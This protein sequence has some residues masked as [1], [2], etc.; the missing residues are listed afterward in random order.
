MPE[1]HDTTVPDSGA[2][3]N[4][5]P[6]KR[7]K[8]NSC[9]ITLAVLLFVA[10][11]ILLLVLNGPGFRTLGKAIALNAASKQGL[12]GDFTINGSI[13]SGFSVEGLKLEG[14]KETD[15]FV[16]VE[17][18][19]VDY[20]ALDAIRDA[21]SFRWL[22]LVEI[23]NANLVIPIPGP[24]DSARTE[25]E[26][27]KPV[28]EATDFSPLW[29][30][31]ETE[32]QI[33][34]LDV[35]LLQEG[36]RTTISKLSLV[37]EPG[38]D[39]QLIVDGLEIPDQ[40]PIEGLEVNL[41]KGRQ[42]LTIGPLEATDYL[43]L[44]SLTVAEPEPG[45]FTAAT[46]L[47]AAGGILTAEVSN[48]GTFTLSQ[49]EDTR[50]DLSKI[51]LSGEEPIELAGEIA[52]LR[53][54]FDGDFESPAT[55]NVSGQIEGKGLGTSEIAIDDLT[56][57]IAD[58][59]A[60]L[61]A[62][63]AD[64][65]LALTATIPFRQAGSA[66]Q[67]ATIPIST[68]GTLQVPSLPNLLE[69][70]VDNL[71]VTGGLSL[72]LKEIQFRDGKTLQSG[73]LRLLSKDL[74]WDG[75]YLSGCELAANVE[76][77]N[78]LTFAADLGLG[79]ANRV[80]ALGNFDLDSLSYRAEAKANL[81]T[82]G[83]LGKVLASLDKEIFAGTISA[84][85][86]GT[87]ELKPQTHEGKAEVELGNFALQDGLPI[88]G[89]L[90][91]D[92][93]GTEVSL[94]RISLKT[95]QAILEGNA[96]WDGKTISLPAM[97]LVAGDRKPLRLSAEIPF[98]PEVKGSLLEQPGDVAMQLVSDDLRVDDITHFF[99]KKPPTEGSLNGMLEAE[100][101]FSELLASGDFT[102]VPTG[103]FAK[104]DAEV[105]LNFDANGDTSVPETWNLN[106]ETLLSGFRYGEIDLETIS[107]KAKTEGE[108]P[109]KLLLADVAF[110]QSTA[111]LN[112]KA[113]LGLSDA[114]KFAD[115]AKRPLLLNG[116]IVFEK[117]EQVL[118]DFAPDKAASLPL[119]GSLNVTVSGLELLEK[120][121][122][123]G[124][125]AID[126]DS[127]ALNGQVF[128]ELEI[129]AAIPEP[130]L[131]DAD[132]ALV[133]DG[134]TALRGNGTY[135]IANQE[136]AGS[137]G[138]TADMSEGKLDEILAGS[139]A[140][141]LIPKLTTLNWSGKGAIEAK[142][143]EGELKLDATRIALATG[144]EPLNLAL[145]GTYSEVS[146]DFPNFSI[147]SKPLD[148]TGSLSWKDKILRLID[149][150]GNSNGREVLSLAA[151]IPLDPEKLTA[152]TWFT[153]ETPLSLTL[154]T[155][156]LSLSNIATLAVPEIPVYGDLTIG[157]E[158]SGTPANPVMD[159]DL[160]FDKISVVQQ[161]KDLPV[162][163]LQLGLDAAGTKASV[164]GMFQHPDINPL[165]VEAQLPFHPGEWA[166][167]SR[168][169]LDESIFAA[170][171]IEP[172]PLGFLISQ[173]PGIEAIEGTVALDAAVKGSLA[174][175]SVSGNGYL[176][177]QKLKMEDRNIPSLTELDLDA[178][179]ADD[180]LVLDKLYAIVAGGIIEGRGQAFL[181]AGEEPELNFNIVGREVLVYRNPDVNV[182]TDADITIRGLWS[183]M[184]ISGE[185]G[186]TNSRFF[187]N[188]DLL[189]I[190]LP[191]R[192]KSVLPTV[193]RTP[194]GGG[195]AYTDLNVGVDIEPFRDWTLN[196]RLHTKDPFLVRSNLVESALNTD[197]TIA[198]TLGQP[199]PNGFLAIKE[200]E[201]S[202]PFS[203]ID[204][205]VGRV[206]FDQETG[207]NG[208]LEFKARAK[209]DKYRA[210]IYLYNNIL[211]PKY[212]L[213][214]NPPLPS[215]DILTLLTTGNVRSDLIG[216]DV[217]SVA[218]S[219]AASLFLKNLRKASAAEDREPGLLD[220]LE[221]RTELEFGGVNPETGEQTLGGKIRLWKQLFF[222]GD[223][224]S[225]SDYRALLKY[226]FRFR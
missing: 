207:F 39:G 162:G 78:Q 36:K 3:S 108:N 222:V 150:R 54:Q 89:K 1:V 132:I 30:L 4:S 218:A 140:A 59:T 141:Q 198:G 213:T 21:K 87:G 92:Y 44:L 11:P 185:L 115:L 46:E 51:H 10:F 80:R 94:P 208:A 106:L 206:E 81:D 77:P 20:S 196:M 202:L 88:T 103:D 13:W 220:E 143:H 153:Q 49:R 28:T 7:S 144:A 189:P 15:P 56:L 14:E 65:E 75:I 109:R 214:S 191:R 210:N 91:A 146:A 95:D 113:A 63:K 107:V 147:Q 85:W 168:K 40:A 165:S 172:S 217:G 174:K 151:S 74:A 163:R 149:W 116:A 152:E 180:R 120:S 110:Q 122:Q 42:A 118:A 127:L 17:K 27:A 157:M 31:L 195:A 112:A 25:E 138:L 139:P 98:N 201:L 84:F 156:A 38:L 223:V 23:R 117:L 145:D 178:R 9:L 209:A 200:G 187:K 121:L 181:R 37:S 66:E 194:R 71:P 64:T 111:T 199:M 167:G 216:D 221:E 171:R 124:T 188:F 155:E 224:D 197:I 179:F 166:D 164:A 160:L 26:T 41:I 192:N 158:A 82:A 193:E 131:L 45:V 93:R 190:G 68:N 6:P 102:F 47:D 97:E 34:N 170:A 219:K 154:N 129:T 50:I 175:P 142:T 204:V 52:A 104:D 48:M 69:G 5:S 62:T 203:S 60:L 225:Q 125:V 137:L 79:P 33:H 2:E 8:K 126:S 99:S 43:T 130:D 226:V 55:W 86:N 101:T 100:G 19:A 136:Y 119:S 73:N 169:V 176:D 83:E 114:E 123:T 186:I 148:V 161:D 57:T 173:V 205:E 135:Q 35:T 61:E 215:E 182:R 183:T 96:S 159:A 134:N 67:L 105:T 72:V 16:E 70:I 177:L 128:D 211:S 58:E 184:D 32:L 90:S 18:L 29:N 12:T 24:T 212:V 22:N 53:M 133:L 76:S